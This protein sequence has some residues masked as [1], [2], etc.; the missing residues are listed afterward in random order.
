VSNKDQ[1]K[2][3]RDAEKYLG[4][5]P[6]AMADLMGVPYKSGTYKDWRSGRRTMPPVALRCL[7]LVVEHTPP[8]G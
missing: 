3:L 1:Q 5:G 4:I 6:V 8:V 7:E 2:V